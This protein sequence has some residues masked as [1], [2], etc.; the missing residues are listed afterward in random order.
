MTIRV[1]PEHNEP[2]A[3]FA[4]ADFRGKH[5][6]EIGSGDGRLTW[7]FAGRTARVTAIDPY[8]DSIAQARRDL[9]RRLRSRVE[10]QAVAFED[11]APTRQSGSFDSV[12]LSWS[13]C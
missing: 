6:L 7:R 11:F 4:V 3:M 1:D 5:V 12:L 10:F 2:R 9:P 13:L 8:E